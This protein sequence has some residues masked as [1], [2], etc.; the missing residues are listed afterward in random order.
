M[1]LKLTIID[2][3]SLKK[4]PQCVVEIKTKEYTKKYNCNGELI[5]QLPKKSASYSLN[6]TAPMYKN[7]SYTIENVE[8]VYQEVVNLEMLELF[9]EEPVTG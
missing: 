5:I 9:E 2:N 8:G 6:I 7:N 3:L 1:F 4:V